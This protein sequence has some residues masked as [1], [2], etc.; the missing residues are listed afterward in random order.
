MP[1]G[2]C[3]DEPTMHQL[4]PV[5]LDQMGCQLHTK[6]IYIKDETALWFYYYY[7]FKNLYLL[8]I[9]PVTVYF[10]KKKKTFIHFAREGGKLLESL[11]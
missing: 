3:Y 2:F 6:K 7:K 8:N 11:Y 5:L 1:E 10:K 9:T 4:L